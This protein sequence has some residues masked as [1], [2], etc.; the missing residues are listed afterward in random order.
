[1]PNYLEILA[2]NVRKRR[3]GLDLSQEELASKTGISLSAVRS[4]ERANG[5][6]TLK[7]LCIIAN[8]LRVDLPDLFEYYNESCLD[9]SEIIEKISSNVKAMDRSKLMILHTVA[10]ILDN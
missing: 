3:K 7:N 1:M 5:N 6:P 8:T 10:K 2:E 9:V 4:I